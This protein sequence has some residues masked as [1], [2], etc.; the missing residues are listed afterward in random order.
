MAK[1]SLSSNSYYFEL[2]IVNCFQ[3]VTL[4]SSIDFDIF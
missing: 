3:N 4:I 2:L 1:L